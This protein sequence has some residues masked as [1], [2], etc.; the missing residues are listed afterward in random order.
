MTVDTREVSFTSGG[1]RCAGT[2]FLPEGSSGPDARVPVVVLAHGF[3]AT[4]RDSLPQFAE[5]FAENGM[6]ALTFDYRGFGDSGGDER[7]VVSIRRELEDVASAISF[8]RSLEETDPERLALWGSSYGGGLAFETAAGDP[9]IRCA[10]AQ[11]PFADG[12]S[13]LGATPPLTAAKLTGKALADL[14]ARKRGRDRV[15]VPA[16]GRPGTLA[17]MTS[18]DALPGFEAITPPDSTHENRVAAAIAL[19]TLRWRPGR[20]ASAI[21]CP[22]LVQVAARDADTPVSPAVKAAGEAPRGEVKSYDCGHFGVY[23]DPTYEQVVTD[24]VAFLHKNL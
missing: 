2:L 7:Q 18:A 12:F 17:A 16:A 10:I 8:A 1:E 22:L 21:R 4:R 13:M 23:L 24:Q 19:E 5:R 11:V 14:V 20:N 9:S 6:A 15:M 3:T